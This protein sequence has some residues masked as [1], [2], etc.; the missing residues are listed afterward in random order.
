MRFVFT[1]YSSA[2]EFDDPAKWLRRINGYTGILEALGRRHSV[3]GIE[4][5]NYEGEFS[6]EGV[7]YNFIRL[8]K[9]VTRFP[10]RMHRMIKNMDPDVVVVNGIIFPLQ[11]IQLRRELGKKVKIILLHRSEI[12]GI[13]LRKFLQKWADRS[14]DAYVFSSDEFG[15][16]WMKSGIIKDAGKV[17]EAIPVSSSFHSFDKLM[18]R[19]GL[20]V[21]GSPVFLWVGRLNANKDPLTV[22][23]GFLEYLTYQPSAKLYMIYQAGDLAD[24]LR[25]M[26]KAQPNIKLVGAI[27]H[28]ELPAW[29]SAA[30]FFISGSHYE[31]GGTAASEAMSCGCIPILTNIIS[32]RRMT[33]PGQCG[34]LYEP[35]NEKA[36]LA[37]L[38]KTKEM[39][40][41]KESLLAKQQ[42]RKELSFDAIA[43]K[44]EK[45]VAMLDKK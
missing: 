4:R 7:H 3:T 6:Q 34:L 9:K 16:Q 37:A 28:E 2:P 36:L 42:F 27:R 45:V 12:P 11:V 5:I 13:R 44:I 10:Q 25:D 24:S 39:D 38:L 15:D 19:A 43:G 17:H 21:D 20:K 33:G 41:E 22:V 32:F 18:A 35:G 1:S 40:R 29:Y 14:V 8:R 26:V 31:G 23:K 30:D